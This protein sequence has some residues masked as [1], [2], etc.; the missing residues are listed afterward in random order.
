MWLWFTAQEDRCRH[1]RH[2]GAFSNQLRILPGKVDLTRGMSI[3]IQRK[4]TTNVQTDAWN[5]KTPDLHANNTSRAAEASKLACLHC[6]WIKFALGVWKGES[7]SWLCSLSLLPL[8]RELVGFS[9]EGGRQFGKKNVK[10]KSVCNV[11]VRVFP[12]WQF[13]F[14]SFFIFYHWAGLVFF[15]TL[16]FITKTKIKINVLLC[17]RLPL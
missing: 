12:P 4:V 1:A 2:D 15:S 14:Y 16:T 7:M 5:T 3:K 10:G 9:R 17:W 8:G 6:P 13:P 11:R